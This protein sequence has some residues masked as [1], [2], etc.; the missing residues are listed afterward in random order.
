MTCHVTEVHALEYNKFLLQMEE[1]GGGCH[2]DA[3]I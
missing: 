3:K 2:S 1:D